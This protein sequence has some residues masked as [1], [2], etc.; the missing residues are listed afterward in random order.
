MATP[1]RIAT[2]TGGVVVTR[3]SLRA[4]AARMTFFDL[5]N[6]GVLTGDPRASTEEVDVRGD[7]LEVFTREEGLERL[8]VRSNGRIEYRADDAADPD[9]AGRSL[10]TADA[11]DVWFDLAD[12]GVYVSRLELRVEQASIE[13][14]VVADGRTERDVDVEA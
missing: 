5:E 9:D 4:A 6:R 11:M 10:L 7:T 3:D 8:L 12:E 2:A 14:A 1:T 13:I